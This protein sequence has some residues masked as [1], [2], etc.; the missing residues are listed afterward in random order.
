MR[1]AALITCHNRREKTLACI[2]ALFK[3]N[4]PSL[5]T[6][7]VY[8]VDDGS[9]DNTRSLV[10]ERY[11]QVTVI[12]GDGNLYWSGGMRLALTTAQSKGFDAY[13]WLND[14]TLLDSGAIQKVLDCANNISTKDAI[15][16][17]ATRDENT[18]VLT[19]GGLV[20]Q[21]SFQPNTY[22]RLGVSDVGQQCQ[23]MNGNCVLI[24][25]QVVA[26]IGNIDTA[27]VHALGDWDYGLRARA[28]GFQI[29]VAPGFVGTCSLNPPAVKKPSEMKSF[30]TQMRTICNAK[31]LP[32]HA[33]KTFVKR[34]YGFFWPIYFARPY[35]TTLFRT[36]LANLRRYA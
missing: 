28:A 13:L 27:F 23:T 8:L 26:A 36:F 35:A 19:Y 20:A 29:W 7:D 30:S 18:G 1:I 16:V 33:W 5:T 24:P 11:P 15:I 21:S 32:P 6:I 22:I 17:G 14:D 10:N 4:T 25:K 31:N 34:H 3:C 12:V 9:T 2:E